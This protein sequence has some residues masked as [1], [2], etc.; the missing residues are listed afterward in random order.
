MSF[1]YPSFLW[2]LLALAIPIIIHLFNF[3]R[4][5]TV[6]F[7]NVRF[8][9]QVKEETTS[10]N[11]LKHLMVLLS[12]CLAL[13]F[14]VFAFAQP[15]IPKDETK[16][17]KGA[18]TV[19]VYVDNSFSMNA[20]SDDVSLFEKAK[21][22][23]REIANAYGE[24]DQFQVVTNDF[25]GKHQR[26]LNKE[27]FL[28]YVDEIQ[29][30]PNVQLLSSVIERQKQA[31]ESGE[32]EV[33]NS[34]LISDFQKNVVDFKNDTSLNIFFVPL[35][36]VEQ[37]NVFIDSIWFASP[38]QMINQPNQ[39]LVRIRNTGNA[40]VDNSRL[41]LKINDQTK[42]FEEFSVN[43][44]SSIE[45]TITYTITE[46]GWHNGELALT[47]YPITT[48]D[49]YF[50]TF[51]VE[52][53]LKVLSINQSRENAFLRALFQEE[54]SFQLENQNI[55]Q[56]NYQTIAGNQLIILNEL[57]AMPSGLAN[58]LKQFLQ[59][60][61]SVMVFPGIDA[62]IASYNSFLRNCG[63]NSY[64]ARE[65]V[66]KRIDYINVKQEVFAG[67]FEKMPKNIDLPSVKK[68]FPMTRYTATNEQVLLRLR[69]GNSFLSKYTV[70]SGKLYLSAAP[71]DNKITNIPAH[72]I[73]APMIHKITLMAGRDRQL[74][75]TIGKD[76][77]VEYENN[78]KKSES[79]YKLKGKTEE[80]IPGQ[81]TLGSKLFLSLNNQLKNAGIYE[82]FMEE[83][84]PL[85]Y[86]GFNFDRKESILDYFTTDQ[87][88][89][90]YPEGNVQ[91]LDD[92]NKDLSMEVGEID[93]GWVLWKWCIIAALA[94]LFF[95]I[96][97]LRFWR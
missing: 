80:F 73:F 96:L 17:V 7:T 21:F 81:R 49:S 56:L 2:A 6:Y 43:A 53:K 78:N 64:S 50:F 26:L 14:L 75:Y 74:A 84:S 77:F 37:Q 5:K 19:S 30:S 93:K 15:F 48:D 88:K 11:K 65:D 27:D 32:S 55:G 87:L 39:I 76:D 57:N 61:G 24:S 94:F 63:A 44:M 31:M 35:Q 97:L 83:G 70:G 58:E 92:A 95:E 52:E 71:M 54:P 72:G 89:Q 68:S 42:A 67:V 69:D 28:A 91:F 29:I 45:D 51:N 20:L 41:T 47:D 25:E 33:N 9:K 62:D 10:R 8:L 60:G 23:A 34:F 12:R 59:D 13:A 18:K 4:Y 38:V 40:R 85:A 22:K 79:V 1:L 3:R 66:E 82:L 46:A 90:K 36:S 16:V 86:F